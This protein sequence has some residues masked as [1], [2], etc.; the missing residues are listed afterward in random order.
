[1][2]QI[3]SL[4]LQQLTTIILDLFQKFDSSSPLG[5]SKS[6]TLQVQ[7]GFSSSRIPYSSTSI[8]QFSD[9]RPQF[10]FHL[11]QHSKLNHLTSSS[12]RSHPNIIAHI[13]TNIAVNCHSRARPRR[14]YPTTRGSR[15]KMAPK[16]ELLLVHL[17]TN[18]SKTPED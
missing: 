16:P 18:R 9:L 13:R 5:R 17:E 7:M 6:S 4:G 2:A 1:M 3:N 12:T 14:K 10:E 11:R 15:S 8:I